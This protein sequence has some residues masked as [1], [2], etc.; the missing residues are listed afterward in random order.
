MPSD[1]RLRLSTR[2]FLL[3]ALSILLTALLFLALGW[4]VRTPNDEGLGAQRVIDAV[5]IARNQPPPAEP[6]NP[7]DLL[8]EAPPPPPASPP[9]LGQPDLP[10]L[11]VPSVALTPVD[12]S[13]INVPLAFGSREG[14]LG[15][16]AFSGFGSGNG[17]G[18]NGNGNGAGGVGSGGRGWKGK[19][20]VPLSTA[21]PQMPEWACKQ[22]LSG[23]V[24]ALFVVMPN[25]HVQDVRILDAD[26][27]GVFEAAAV[28]SISKWLYSATGKAAEVKQRVPM[29]HEDCAYNW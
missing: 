7:P 26:P 15:G 27:K 9:A 2:W 5:S 17:A 13:N 18:G 4:L 20:L 29:N 11:D 21:R 10:P 8:D 3:S 12:L 28:Q 25:G 14:I 24:E 23:W 22:K 16:G 1:L 19:P 6:P